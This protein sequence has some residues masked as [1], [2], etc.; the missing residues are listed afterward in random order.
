MAGSL[1]R[2]VS[3]ALVSIPLLAVLMI[4]PFL[5]AWDVGTVGAYGPGDA[6]RAWTRWAELAL[7]LSVLAFP[8]GALVVSV[9]NLLRTVLTL[10]GLR[11]AVRQGAPSTQVPHPVQ[12]GMAAEWTGTGM[13]V[14]SL[15][16]TAMLAFPQVLTAPVRTWVRQQVPL[17]GWSLVVLPAAVIA[18]V[19]VF[20]AWRRGALADV[21]DRWGEDQRKAA[22]AAARA[23]VPDPP[24]G[25]DGKLQDPST[26]QRSPMD[27]AGDRVNTAA[28][29]LT[30]IAVLGAAVTL[31]VGH[32]QIGAGLVTSRS[33]A[34]L[35]TSSLLVL[36][37]AFAGYVLGA[38][39]QNAAQSRELRN[40]LAAVQQPA[41]PPPQ[42][43]PLARHW[44]AL[45]APWV[46]CL[47]LTGA[48]VLLLALPAAFLPDG[49]IARWA[50]PGLVLAGGLLVVA[51]LVDV[52]GEHSTR[53]R[54]NLVLARWPM[55]NPSTMTSE[56]RVDAAVEADVA[57]YGQQPGLYARMTAQQHAAQ[58]YVPPAQQ[59]AA[60]PYAPPAQQYPAQPYAP[61]GRGQPPPPPVNGAAPHPVPPGPPPAGGQPPPPAGPSA[62]RR[63]WGL[64]KKIRGRGLGDLYR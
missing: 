16:V 43:G 32:S 29:V 46:D 3:S 2:A 47:G 1:V 54:R 55:P 61:P 36:A 9:L 6:G 30:G 18:L 19:V 34:L 31:P 50:G 60:Q 49:S 48:M 23:R 58:P 38:V 44:R 59:H 26:L 17:E 28:I 53:E 56:D 25:P 62:A 57:G 14:S 15:L 35:F 42:L 21:T 22:E 37:V 10:A 27:A 12:W 51:A 41:G 11:R 45:T 39:L 24:R 13:I 64:P 20:R 7:G 33:E 5:A 63:A 8:V 4:L 40:L 52:V